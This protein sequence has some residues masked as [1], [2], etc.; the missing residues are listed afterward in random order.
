MGRRTLFRF[1]PGM[2]HMGP[3]V[4]AAALLSFA[5]LAA[6]A[7][8]VRGQDLPPALPPGAELSGP[9]KSALRLVRREARAVPL[10][11]HLWALTADLPLMETERREGLPVAFLRGAVPALAVDKLRAPSLSAEDFELLFVRAR[12]LAASGISIELADAEMA[13]RQAV[14]EYVLQKARAKPSFAK[15]LLA[16]TRR[17]QAEM[18]ARRKLY[19]QVDPLSPKARLLFPG[20][21]PEGEVAGA[22]FDLYLFSEDPYL[23]YESCLDSPALSAEAVRL[24]EVE[25]FL[26]LRG[27]DLD[28]LSFPAGGRFA[29]A[30]GRL[31]PGRVA[32]A[33]QRVRD[34]EGLQRLREGLGLFRTAGRDALM[35]RVNQWV[36]EGTTAP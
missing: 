24:D 29:L 13:A 12:W 17:A 7:G 16:S 10:G 1:P 35:K 4:R 9:L 28:R 21:R 34:G 15:A 27:G 26:S 11:R 20:P 5:L 6:S 31:Y 36:R 32:R 30:E 25:D 3:Q 33:A 8:Q 22:G 18:E 23:F 14:L 19:A 2:G